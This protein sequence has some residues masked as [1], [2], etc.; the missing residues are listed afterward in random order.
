MPRYAR[1]DAL[2][3]ALTALA[4]HR[5]RVLAGGTDFYAGKV[6]QSVDED[7]LD[8]TAIASLRGI[9]EHADA[10]RIGATTT[11][12]QIARA[13]L[14]E[15]LRALQWAAREVGG[16]QIQNTGTV[17]GNL[18][19]ASPAADGVPPLLALDASVELRS[20]AGSRRLALEAFV[21]GARQIALAPDELLTAVWIPKPKHAARSTFFKLGARRYQVISVVM[22]AVQVEIEAERVA[23]AGI[24][25]GAC[26]PVA[27][28]LNALEQALIGVPPAQAWQCVRSEHLRMLAPLSDVRGD[29][30]YRAHAALC[31]VRDALRELA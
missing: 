3:D 23:R 27:L 24:A 16:V 4:Q 13:P 25:V 30:R 22:V 20:R 8:I 12:S 1:P 18:C 2:S 28:R 5:M 11:W 21:R 19:N 6:G 14:P 17:G 31:T 9:E 10:I 26:S 15:W 7:L 29:A